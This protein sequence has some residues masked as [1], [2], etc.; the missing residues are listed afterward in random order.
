MGNLCALSQDQDTAR[1]GKLHNLC[2]A[3]IPLPSQEQSMPAA[4]QGRS[5]FILLK[6]KIQLKQN[7]HGTSV[8]QLT[9]WGYTQFNISQQLK[10]SADKT[11]C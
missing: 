4:P 3:R 8:L 7:K 1:A 2:A 5:S 10:S 11:N 6:A 9:F